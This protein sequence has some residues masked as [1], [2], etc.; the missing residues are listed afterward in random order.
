MAT[1]CGYIIIWTIR[2]IDMRQ[3]ITLHVEWKKQV[4][5]VVLLIGQG[6]LATMTGWLI[7]QISIFVIL[8]IINREYIH[9]LLMTIVARCHIVN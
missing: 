4:L 2:T 3:F 6:V 1:M 7:T 9:K 5:S 8:I